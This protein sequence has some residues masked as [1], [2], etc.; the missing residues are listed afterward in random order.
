MPSPDKLTDQSQRSIER[1]RR[2]T[3]PYGWTVTASLRNGHVGVTCTHD[4]SEQHT[5]GFA[6]DEDSHAEFVERCL[7]HREF[8]VIASRPD[9]MPHVSLV[10]KLRR[11]ASRGTIWDEHGLEM[12]AMILGGEGV[13]TQAE[14]AWLE[15]AGPTWSSQD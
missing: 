2:A 15:A 9:E 6:N 11:A 5:I 8:A 1:I 14:A 4:L 7:A 13:L 12:V 3:E 10:R